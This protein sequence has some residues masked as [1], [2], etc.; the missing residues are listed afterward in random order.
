ML[1]P[2]EKNAHGSR[3]TEKYGKENEET[4]EKKIFRRRKHFNC[5]DIEL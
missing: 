5:Q 2:Q 1:Q 3:N 4:K